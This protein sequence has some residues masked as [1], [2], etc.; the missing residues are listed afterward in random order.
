MFRQACGRFVGLRAAS[1]CSVV[2]IATGVTQQVISVSSL[3]LAKTIVYHPSLS[4][5]P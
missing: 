5:P 1:L 2:T 4:A 3:N